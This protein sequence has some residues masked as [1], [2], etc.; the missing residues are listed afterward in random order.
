M[1]PHT[2][3][4]VERQDTAAYRLV[5]TLDDPGRSHWV[6]LGDASQ[7]VGC[8]LPWAGDG[9]R[10]VLELSRDPA[11][12]LAQLEAG[13]A[14]DNGGLLGRAAA[15]WQ[16]YRDEGA[17]SAAASVDADLVKATIDGAWPSPLPAIV[18]CLIWLRARRRL[19]PE[20][21]EDLTALFPTWSDTRVLWAEALLAT[22]RDISPATLAE[23][24][25]ELAARALPVTTE[26]FGY[27]IDQVHGLGQLPQ[28]QDGQRRSLG[29]TWGRLNAATR[30]LRPGG[31]F[32]VFASHAQPVTGD[33]VLPAAY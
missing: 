29:S 7:R 33:L 17:G 14:V 5:L 23:V 22:E 27:A 32:T 30:H 21:L 8:V 11:G 19:E 25:G 2:L 9:T 26:A 24:L 1:A 20:W 28:L 31:L 12:G 18:A 4:R 15:A 16:G 10:Y 13:L 3:L 6:E